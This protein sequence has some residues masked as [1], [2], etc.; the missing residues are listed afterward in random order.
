MRKQNFEP[1]KMN[2]QLFAKEPENEPSEGKAGSEPDNEPGDGEGDGENEDDL[3]NGISVL[4][5]VC[6]CGES[7]TSAGI[8]DSG[9]GGENA[10]H[11]HKTQTFDDH[12]FL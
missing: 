9:N 7:K 6:P 4:E 12:L 5:G 10:N 2:L 11:S 8:K 3:V 1:L